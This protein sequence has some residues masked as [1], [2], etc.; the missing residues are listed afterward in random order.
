M[1]LSQNSSTNLMSQD[2]P[3]MGGGGCI[4]LWWDT[5]MGGGDEIRWSKHTPQCSLFSPRCSPLPPKGR[6]PLSPPAAWHNPALGLLNRR[7]WGLSDGRHMTNA[8]WQKQQIMFGLLTQAKLL[9]RT[10][11]RMISEFSVRMKHLRWYSKESS[12]TSFPEISQ[13]GLKTM[14]TQPD[15]RSTAHNYLGAKQHEKSKL[16]EQENLELI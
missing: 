10:Y 12:K 8:G 5:T 7:L 6:V 9:Q 4:H 11:K 1:A 15:F 3:N 14:S 2:I 16:N 13:W